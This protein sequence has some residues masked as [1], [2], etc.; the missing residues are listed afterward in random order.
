MGFGASPRPSAAAERLPWPLRGPVPALS[1]TQWPVW[2][3]R[4]SACSR[5]STPRSGT[6]GR[7]DSMTNRPSSTDGYELYRFTLA[8]KKRLGCAS[9]PASL[10]WA[11]ASS[12]RHVTRAAE[13]LGH[14]IYTAPVVD[15]V[16]L[17]IGPEDWSSPAVTDGLVVG[18]DHAALA[19][20]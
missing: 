11:S 3:P 14:S 9:G 7:S 1:P 2:K 6:Y 16:R 12:S 13:S 4:S 17:G 10:T 15:A 20:S 8:V 19:V 5:L 18:C